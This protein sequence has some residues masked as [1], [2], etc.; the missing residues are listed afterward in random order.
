VRCWSLLW[1]RRWRKSSRGD[2]GNESA[3]RAAI[4]K[5]AKHNASSPKKI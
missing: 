5:A 3:I 2:H 1:D 4:L